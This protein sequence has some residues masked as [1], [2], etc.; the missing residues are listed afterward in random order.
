MEENRGQCEVELLSNG[1]GGHQF[2]VP[3]WYIEKEQ[4]RTSAS[5]GKSWQVMASHGKSWQVMASH[6]KSP[7]FKNKLRN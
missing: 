6:G 5:H 3:L 1:L 7:Q 2:A 4:R